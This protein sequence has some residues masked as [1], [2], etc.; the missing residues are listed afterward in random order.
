[1]NAAWE[2]LPPPTV[3]LKRI[4]LYLGLPDTKKQHSA[5]ANTPQDALREALAA[6]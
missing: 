5:P 2:A 1:L 4:S 3:Q 6:G